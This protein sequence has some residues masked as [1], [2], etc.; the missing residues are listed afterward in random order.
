MYPKMEG[1]IGVSFRRYSLRGK[2][3]ARMSSFLRLGM[4]PFHFKESVNYFEFLKLCVFSPV[5]RIHRFFI[6]F[7]LTNKSCAS[8]K[9]WENEVILFQVCDK[10]SHHVGFA[11]DRPVPGL[12]RCTKC[13]RAKSPIDRLKLRLKKRSVGR[14]NQTMRMARFSC[15]S[16]RQD[17][18][19]KIATDPPIRHV[20]V[21]LW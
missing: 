2:S 20:I 5:V 10:S 9:V 13:W 3:A 1:N 17:S 18:L 7:S 6:L 12:V 19:V 15:I 8:P 16:V 11:C 14:M 4:V 21:T